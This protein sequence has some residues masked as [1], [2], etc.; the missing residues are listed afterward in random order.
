[1][2]IYSPCQTHLKKVNLAT[3]FCI[4]QDLLTCQNCPVGKEE[5]IGTN[6][7]LPSEFSDLEVDT[8][9]VNRSYPKEWCDLQGKLPRI[10]YFT[11][12]YTRMK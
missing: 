7:T 12:P 8:A 5:F 2:I 3:M 4:F 1:M 11:S 9:R 10:G 6:S